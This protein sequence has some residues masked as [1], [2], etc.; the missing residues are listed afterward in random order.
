MHTLN[1][2][3]FTNLPF[4]LSIKPQRLRE[5]LEPFRDYLSA[6]QLHPDQNVLSH[7]EYVQRLSE[8]F[9]S[10]DADTL[11]ETALGTAGARLR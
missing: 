1:Y 8:A 2:Q 9:A 6:K 10:P 4:L 11:A 3:R 5:F 7:E